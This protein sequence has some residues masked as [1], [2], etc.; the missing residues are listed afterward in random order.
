M[1]AEVQGLDAWVA[2]LSQVEIPVLRQTARELARL[3]QTPNRVDA[4]SVAQVLLRDPL[5]V[6]KLLR[7]F[8]QQRR[9][10]RST[11]VLQVEQ[12]LMMLGLEPFFNTVPAQPLVD[13]VLQGRVSALTAVLRVIKRSHRASIFAMEW[14]ARRL[15]MHYDEVRIAALLYHLAELLLWCFAPDRMGEILSRQQ[16]DRTLRSK[17]AQQAVFGFSSAEL[18]TELAKKWGLPELLLTLMDERSSQLDRVRNVILAVNLARH[19][20]NGWDDAALP[21]DYRDIGDFLRLSS[22]QVMALVGADTGAG[23]PGSAKA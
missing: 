2:H 21:D 9:K 3:H 17:A 6:A 23:V 8:E 19:S 15:D 10:G 18:Q 4:R 22:D 16:E 13:D 7:H 11:D 14:A 12:V 1:A 5:M 20:G